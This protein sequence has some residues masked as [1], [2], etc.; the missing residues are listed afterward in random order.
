VYFGGGVLS[1]FDLYSMIL[2]MFTSRVL[3]INESLPTILGRIIGVLTFFFMCFM[4]VIIFLLYFKLKILGPL[5]E[6]FLER[7]K[8]RYKYFIKHNPNVLYEKMVG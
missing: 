4:T 8:F 5:E 6:E 7:C 1:L 2:K 3:F